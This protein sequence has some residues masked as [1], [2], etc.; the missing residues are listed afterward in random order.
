MSKL[1]LSV[2]LT[3]LVLV[4]VLGGSVSADEII[5]KKEILQGWKY[6]VDSGDTYQDVGV[7]GTSLRELMTG[8]ERAV[9]EMELYGKRKVLAAFTGYTCG[10]IV[11]G[12]LIVSVFDT[13]RDE[14]QYP[15][16]A[17]I[18]VGVISNLYNNSA[19]NHLK[20]AVRV[21]NRDQKRL[22]IAVCLGPQLAPRRVGVGSALRISF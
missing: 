6:S 22:S 3:F 17:A 19:T 14:Y 21:Y 4:I 20:E 10:A 15:L 13:W 2:L 12:L 7:G 8:N 1:V 9:F 18:G 5:L 16:I 11:V